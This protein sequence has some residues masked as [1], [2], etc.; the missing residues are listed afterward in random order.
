[1]AHAQ[2]LSSKRGFADVSANYS[3][4]QAT[5]ATWYYTWG[6]GVGTPA[7]FDAD[8]YPMFWTTPSTTTIDTVLAREPKFILGFN[9]PER[10]D[11]ANRTV[12]QAIASWTTI[13]NK[14]IAYNTA[15]GWLTL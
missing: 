9:E 14:T 5:G 11:Q 4:L 1:V 15:T 13:S 12:A 3:N 10:A 6:T 7:N 8:H 2:I